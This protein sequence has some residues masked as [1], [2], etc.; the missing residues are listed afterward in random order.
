MGDKEAFEFF[1]ASVPLGDY[2][3]SY[4]HIKIVEMDLPSDIQAI[5][6]LYEI[7]W[8]NKNFVEFD[9]FYKIYLSKKKSLL[10]DFRKRITMCEDC[11]YR[12]LKAR[13]YRTWA[14][15]ITQIHG[16]YVA[17]RVF[18]KGTARMSAQLDSEGAD[19]QV[20]YKGHTLNY[21]VKKES[22]SGV[23]SAKSMPK[24]RGEIIDLPYYVPNEL[25]FKTPKK[26]NGELRVPYIRFISNKTLK[27]FDNGFVV[28]TEDAFLPKKKEIDI[29]V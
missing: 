7:Y 17:E 10:E 19:I 15:L 16:G 4:K 8:D 6:L 3:A 14:S 23:R 24:V 28:F 29:K 27:R 26:R 18:G 13:I 9:T 25:I 11:F 22:Q 1:L 20:V 12:G 5:S 21:Q 2:R